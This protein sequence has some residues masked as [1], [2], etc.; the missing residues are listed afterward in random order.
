MQD[1]ATS[2]TLILMAPLLR[3]VSSSNVIELQAYIQPVSSIVRLYRSVVQRGQAI[4]VV[5]DPY[6]RRNCPPHVQVPYWLYLAHQ[7]RHN[8]PRIEMKPTMIFWACL[9]VH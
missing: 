1:A 5:V 4:Q 2:L 3:R 6:A 7:A 8:T 9:S